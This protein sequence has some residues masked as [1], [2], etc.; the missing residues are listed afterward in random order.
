MC[1]VNVVDR[2]IAIV[3][4]RYPEHRVL[5]ASDAAGDAG[6]GGSIGQQRA[7]RRRLLAQSFSVI[8]IRSLVA[9][10][11]TAFLARCA[12]SR[13]D[14]PVDFS[15]FASAGRDGD[16]GTFSASCAGTASFGFAALVSFGAA[17][18]ASASFGAAGG[19]AA[20]GRTRRKRRWVPTLQSVR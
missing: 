5:F 8:D 16:G 7:V 4:R 18:A 3:G 13:I 10:D 17:F 20:F 12:R 1:A 19:G 15:G 2:G 11:N 14:V 6:V 9:I